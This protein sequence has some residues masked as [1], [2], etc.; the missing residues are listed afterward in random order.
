MKRMIVFGAVFCLLISLCGCNHKTAPA[1]VTATTLPVYTFTSQLCLGT[2]I[3]VSRLVTENLSCL[4]DYTLQ[5][6]QMVQI[7]GARLI[8]IS[9]AGFED[10]LSDAIAG[11]DNVLDASEGVPLLCPEGP[12]D[13]HHHESDPHIWLSTQNARIMAENIY[14]G[15][16]DRFPQSRQQFQENMAALTE[17]FDALDVYARETLS[18]LSDVQLITFHD[19]F[20]YFAQCFDLEI[21]HALEEEAGSEASAKELIELITLV[22]THHLPAV[23]TEVS[24]TSSAA[25]IVA[26]ET[27]ARVLSL[28]MGMSQR[29]YFEAMRYNLDAVKEAWK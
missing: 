6:G 26:A 29:D 7:E 13:G 14:A 15:L 22:N 11:K 5:V 8:V 21:L 23:F 1:A 12:H 9:G 17:E 10:F 4:H 16:C 19:G 27:G 3:T 20:S 24:G 2:E 28:D 25:G 18:G